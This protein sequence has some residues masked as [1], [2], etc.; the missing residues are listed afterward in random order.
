MGQEVHNFGR[1]YSVFRS[2]E[3]HGD[4]EVF[5]KDMVRQYTFGRT[6][7]LREMTKEEYNS[8]CAALER[9]TGKTATLKKMRS[10]CLFRMQKLGI[11]TTDWTRIDAFCKDKRIAGKRFAQLDI[12]DLEALHKKLLTI[13][14]KGGLS[15]GTE[16][17]R[18]SSPKTSKLPDIITVYGLN[19]KDQTV[20]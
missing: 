16:C 10:S 6:E 20:N 13:E 7:S 9:I 14:R 17:P 8:M 1:F 2:I 5:K 19:D 15:A 11:D 3:Y 4:R 18:K 12:A